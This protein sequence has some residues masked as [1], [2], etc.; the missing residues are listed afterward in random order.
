[1]EKY[2]WD[3]QIEYLKT[4]RTQMWNDDYF[5]FL[6][7]IPQSKSM[8]SKMVDSVIPTGMVICI[9]VNR[10]M[11]EAGFYIHDLDYD[12]S[13][14]EYMLKK[15]WEDE[16]TSGGRDYLLG[17]KVP[18]YMEQLGLEGVG[19]RLNDFVEF[20]SPQQDKECYKKYLADFIET[21]NLQSINI[22]SKN[23]ISM[24]KARSLIISY[25][26]KR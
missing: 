2:F 22:D 3:S 25:G 10:K 21:D 16:L 8:L 1:M 18:I 9:E 19:A 12:T 6:V 14:K 13:E 11:E 15:Q 20:I 4:T 26:T 17:I 23:K 5:E 24:L 7:N